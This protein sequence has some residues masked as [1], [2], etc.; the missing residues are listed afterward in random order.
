M[1]NNENETTVRELEEGQEYTA[2]INFTSKGGE[3]KVTIQVTRAPANYL[4]GISED[5][6]VQIPAAWD[7]ANRVLDSLEEHLESEEHVRASKPKLT[8]V[9]NETVN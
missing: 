1:S 7:L 5:D 3:G 6:Y 2:Q 4:D 8:I 9:P